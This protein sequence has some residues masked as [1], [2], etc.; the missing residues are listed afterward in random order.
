MKKL[1]ALLLFGLGAVC[2][3]GGVTTCASS[4]GL[5][6]DGRAILND[7]AATGVT[8]FYFI[9]V[10][11]GHSYTVEV[12]NNFTPF[13]AND[14][15][16]GLLSSAC[17]A[18]TQTFTDVTG[19]DPSLAGTNGARISFVAAFNTT[20][21]VSVN[22]PA[23]GAITYDI[24]MVDTTLHNPRWSTFSGFIT[25][26][27]FRNTTNTAIN[28]TLTVNTVLGTALAPQVVTFSIPANSE[29]FKIVSPTGD[30]VIGGQH[31][32][33]ASLAY[34]GPAGAIVADAYFI[35]G[36]TTIIVPS[37][38]APRDHQH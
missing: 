30:V 23:P 34:F 15:V 19:F 38:F 18:T 28:A 11:S 26:Y 13:Q 37:S 27:A 16:L 1:F 22:N 17:A 5:T 31:A 36:S 20:L 14:L 4:P 8:N 7:G 2:A 29:V 21:N 10:V 3:Q 24:R 33:F 35:N 6:A 32:G 25:Q 9:H 12:L